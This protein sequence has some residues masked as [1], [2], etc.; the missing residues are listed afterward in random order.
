MP[1]LSPFR[2][3][4]RLSTSIPTTT[5]P[6][7]STSYTLTATAPLQTRPTPSLL[8]TIRPPTPLLSASWS[9]V[10]SLLSSP[11]SFSF[12]APPAAVMAVVAGQ[13]TRSASYGSEYQPSQRIRKRRHG[14]L[15][16]I[17]TKNGRKTIMRRRF[18]GKAKLSH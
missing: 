16:R 18:R 3:L 5:T 6:I 2:P 11:S 8:R 10:L 1:R 12:T 9:T 4:L 13:Q 15:A 7:A 17:K 14:F